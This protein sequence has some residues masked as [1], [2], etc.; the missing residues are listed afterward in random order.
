MVKTFKELRKYGD[1]KVRSHQKCSND[2]KLFRT[3]FETQN[4]S[5]ELDKPKK[6]VKKQ[7]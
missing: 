5:F 7:R 6:F 3:F 4:M 1:E 2:K